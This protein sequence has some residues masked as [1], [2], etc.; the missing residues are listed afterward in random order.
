MTKKLAPTAL[1]IAGGALCIGSFMAWDWF[2]PPPQAGAPT[3]TY[4]MHAGGPV[5]LVA[6]IIAVISGFRCLRRGNSVGWAVACLGT[7][8]LGL[9]VTVR[10]FQLDSRV[11][12]FGDGVQSL[13]NGLEICLV[14]SVVGTVASLFLVI[15][16]MAGDATIEVPA[17]T[18]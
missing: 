5:T 2:G 16:A 18:G 14:A 10:S 1:L 11:P 8:A 17:A 3:A 6:G 7:L 15:T 4:G 9:L 12:R 13:G